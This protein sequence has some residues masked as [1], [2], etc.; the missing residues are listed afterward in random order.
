MH[1][2]KCAKCQKQRITKCANKYI[3]IEYIFVAQLIVGVIN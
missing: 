2:Y 1:A 3:Y